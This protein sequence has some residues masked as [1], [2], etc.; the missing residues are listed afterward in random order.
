MHAVGSL[1]GTKRPD[2][3]SKAK[4]TEEVKKNSKR[5]QEEEDFDK[6]DSG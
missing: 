3:L 6:E 5:E 4:R 1:S 2:I